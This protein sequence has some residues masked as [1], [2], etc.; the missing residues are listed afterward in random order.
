L[1]NH[2]NGCNEPEALVDGSCDNPG[3]GQ[4]EMGGVIDIYAYLDNVEKGTSTLATADQDVIGTTWEG[5]PSMTIPAGGSAQVKLEWATDQ[6]GYGNEI[7]SD[8][9]TFD[10]GFDLVQVVTPTPAL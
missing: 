3:E 1:V 4:G 5:L 2:E 8:S 10:V 6:E 9:I 7:Q